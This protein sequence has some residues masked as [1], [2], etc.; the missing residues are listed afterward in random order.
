MR[1]QLEKAWD[2]TCGW[3]RRRNATREIREE[4]IQVKK[5][6]KVTLN[7]ASTRH[8]PIV[9]DVM[10]GE[11]AELAKDDFLKSC[12]PLSFQWTG[13]NPESNSLRGFLLLAEARNWPEFL[14][15]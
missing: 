9:N 13:M 15:A 8:G 10:G 2:R 1:G 3:Y 11:D 7:V 12:G 14:E 6:P 4:N 5:R